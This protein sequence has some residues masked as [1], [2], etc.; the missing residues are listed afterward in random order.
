LLADKEAEIA[1]RRA[2]EDELR[3]AKASIETQLEEART[4]LLLAERRA[5]LGTLAGGVG[6]ELRNIAQI[7]VAAVDELAAAV[8]ADEDVAALARRI[9]PEL[10]RVAD[11]ITQHGDR[12]M[13]LAR[14]GPDHVE[15]MALDGVV[16]DVAAMLKLAGK[17]GR[18]ELVLS[19]PPAPVTVT[20]NRTRIEQILVNLIINAV[21]AITAPG[22][23]V[24]IKVHPVRDRRVACSVQDTGTGI[25][26]DVLRR[27]FEPFFTTKGD[28]GT[29]LG[30]PVVREI[31]SSYGGGITVDST[32][33]TGTTFTFDLPC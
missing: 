15:P 13:Q 16:R 24:T 18:I 5:T 9:L 33:G 10:E 3:A 30:L 27:I 32:P 4:Q 14:P 28:H 20:V 6:H 26:P 7:Q 1:R 22:G 29:G 17:L 12:L 21:D 11:H 2:V 25:P 31:V 8:R 23:T 19:L